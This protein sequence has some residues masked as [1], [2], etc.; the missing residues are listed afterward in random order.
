[1]I[2]GHRSCAWLMISAK[3]KNVLWWFTSDDNKW[4]WKYIPGNWTTETILSDS[5]NEIFLSS[6]ENDF[7]S[8]IFN[9]DDSNLEDSMNTWYCIQFANP[10]I[11]IT[12]EVNF[13]HS[14]TY[15]KWKR[16]ES[17]PH[18]DWVMSNLPRAR[19]PV[20]ITETPICVL[21]F[22]LWVVI[23]IIS[24]RLSNL[25]FKL[26]KIWWWQIGDVQNSPT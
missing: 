18:L 19:F 16:N 20:W 2:C 6:S 21:V 12:Y 13:C 9:P 17:I 8:T 10:Y 3:L 25:V 7:L 24:Y 14:T 1:M 15:S 5:E 22:K 26:K 11:I 23:L 4:D